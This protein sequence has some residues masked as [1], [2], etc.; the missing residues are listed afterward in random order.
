[1]TGVAAGSDTDQTG[2]TVTAW[3]GDLRLEPLR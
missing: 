2:D 3:F 1:V